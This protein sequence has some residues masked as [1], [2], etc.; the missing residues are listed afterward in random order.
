MQSSRSFLFTLFNLHVNLYY[1]LIRKNRFK[2]RFSPKILSYQIFSEILFS[3]IAWFPW[4]SG[5]HVRLTRGRSPVQAWPETR[6]L[7]NF[8]FWVKTKAKLF[9]YPIPRTAEIVSVLKIAKWVNL[10]QNFVKI[11]TFVIVWVAK[12]EYFVYT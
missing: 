3:T 7:Y 6:L 8:L 4:C 12:S 2:I 10:F 11:Q 1:G 9:H 5:Y